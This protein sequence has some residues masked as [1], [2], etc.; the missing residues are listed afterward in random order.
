M[1]YGLCLLAIPGG[2]KVNGVLLGLMFVAIALSSSL[3][4]VAQIRILERQHAA[5]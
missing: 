1:G 2:G 4:S 3:L 5:D